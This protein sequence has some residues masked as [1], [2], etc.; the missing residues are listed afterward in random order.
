MAKFTGHI[1][2]ESTVTFEATD[3]EHAEE[4]LEGLTVSLGDRR[5]VWGDDGEWDVGLIY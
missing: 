5:V 1:R 2:C 3:E 4:I